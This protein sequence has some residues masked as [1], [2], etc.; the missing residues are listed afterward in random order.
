MRIQKF[1]DRHL[2]ALLMAH[3]AIFFGPLGLLAS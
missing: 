1:A 2:V 3:T